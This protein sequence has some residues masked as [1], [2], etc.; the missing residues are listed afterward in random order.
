VPETNPQITPERI[1]ELIAESFPGDMAIEPL[2]I[3]EERATGRIV[4]DDRHLH[5]G[6]FV[7]G[8][9]WTALA[10]SVAAWATFRNIPPGWDFTTLELK[11]NV[12]SA[13]RLGDEIVAEAIPLHI[14]RSTAVIEVRMRRGEKLVANLVVTQ[15]LLPA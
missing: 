5:P 12:F 1:K 10:D 6:K 2:E 13:G 11:L 4:V 7:H 8:G 14:G 3:S 15:F 9:V